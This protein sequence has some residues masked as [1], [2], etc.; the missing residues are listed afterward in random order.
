MTLNEVLKQ[1]SETRKHIRFRKHQKALYA[2][3]LSALKSEQLAYRKAD[4]RLKKVR[5]GFP[6]SSINSIFLLFH[7]VLDNHAVGRQQT[8]EELLLLRL[9]QLAGGQIISFLSERVAYMQQVDLTVKSLETS[10]RG[11]ISALEKQ[12]ALLSDR[13]AASL[14]RFVFKLEDLKIDLSEANS[15]IELGEK[16]RLHLVDIIRKSRDVQAWGNI[17][18]ETGEEAPLNQIPNELFSHATEGHML[19]C[20][21]KNELGEFSQGR[22]LELHTESLAGFKE[23]YF[24]SLILDWLEEGKVKGSTHLVRKKLNSLE[25]MLKGLKSKAVK[26]ENE[27][28][29]IS[30]EIDSI[31]Q[32]YHAELM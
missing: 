29:V 3:C 31:K 20:A 32:K 18:S 1:V 9:N 5:V 6:S 13:K 26:I 21:F 27:I 19:L 24:R 8:R 7:E 28:E 22:D 4:T 15:A 30:K 17:P 2:K 10:E 11:L 25:A 12:A 14:A 16:A 23:A